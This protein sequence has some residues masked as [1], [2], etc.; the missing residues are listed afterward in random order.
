MSTLKGKFQP[1]NT[2]WHSCFTLRWV[3]TTRSVCIMTSERERKT[4]SK[5]RGCVCCHWLIA[6]VW[7]Y[8]GRPEL[9]AV[10]ILSRSL[11][12]RKSVKQDPYVSVSS[13][14]TQ[15]SEI[16]IEH[17]FYRVTYPWLLPVCPIYLIVMSSAPL[18][19]RSNICACFKAVVID[20]SVVAALCV[21]IQL[22]VA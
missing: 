18:F 21:E 15:R 12:E 2:V 5:S 17:S 3:L 1:E 11:V 16:S 9:Q 19:A 14:L 20:L 8:T 10:R 6:L 7:S 22:H 13:F 4:F